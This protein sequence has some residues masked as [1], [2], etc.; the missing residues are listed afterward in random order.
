[1]IEPAAF[2]KGFVG[3]ITKRIPRPVECLP[4]ASKE[5]G[6]R[7][8]QASECAS[9]LCGR[10]VC[11]ACDPDATNTCPSGLACASSYTIPDTSWLGGAFVCGAH[12]GLVASGQPCDDDTDCA[13]AHCNGA[14]RAQCDDGRACTTA[15]TCPAES[16]LQPGHCSTVG[17]Q[18]GSCQ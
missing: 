15:E 5:I 2:I 7:C 14:V 8:I 9:N 4:P 16:G 12:S 1:M 13:S 10:G 11:S 3:E 6:E 17:I 18:G